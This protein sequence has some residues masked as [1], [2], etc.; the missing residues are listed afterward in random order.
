[1]FAQEIRRTAPFVPMLPGKAI[2]DIEID[3]Q[4]V[5]AGGRVVLDIL[6]TNLDDRSWAHPRRF[7]PERF[8]HV[9]DYEA[10]PTFVPHGGADVHTGHRCPGERLA[11]A[12]LSAAVTVLSDPALRIQAAGLQVNYRRLPTKPASGGRVRSAGSTK[13][14]PFH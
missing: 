7:D 12:G 4:Q 6:G 1:M 8:R 3:G 10:I 14:C 11:I 9:D 13:G 5:V 2:T